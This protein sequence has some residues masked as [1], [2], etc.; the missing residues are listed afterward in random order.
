MKNDD[1]ERCLFVFTSQDTVTTF[2]DL[3][4]LPEH[5]QFIAIQLSAK[6]FADRL[7]SIIDNNP[8]VALDPET[9]CDFQPVFTH[10]ILDALAAFRIDL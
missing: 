10:K 9:D 7:E 5:K 3:M 1:G 6:E 2:V 4:E 8:M